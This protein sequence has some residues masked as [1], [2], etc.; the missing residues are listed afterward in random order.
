MFG[1]VQRIRILKP[2]QASDFIPFDVTRFQVGRVYE[3]GPRL[4]ELLI[5]CGC[6]ETE[7]SSTKGAV[8][9]T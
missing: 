8:E 2:P 6:A 7:S 3:V 4:A 5:V 1:V 9:S